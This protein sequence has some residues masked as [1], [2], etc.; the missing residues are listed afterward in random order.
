[1]PTYNR[2]DDIQIFLKNETPFLHKFDIDIC[3]F[4]SSE[5]EETREVCSQYQ[6][7]GC[8]IKYFR[9]DSKTS[10]NEKMFLIYQQMQK[11]YQF[12]WISH[13]HTLF[14]EEAFAYIWNCLNESTPFFFIRTQ[15][16][17]F[18][19]YVTED[20]CQFLHDSAWLLGRMGASIV[21]SDSFL[22]D[23]DW[24]KYTK[25]YLNNKC[26]NF[27]HIGFYF[28]RACEIDSFLPMTIEIPREYFYDTKRNNKLSWERESIRICT[29]C[30]GKVISSLPSQYINKRQ[31][32]QTIDPYFLTKYKL[33]EFKK[34]GI[35]SLSVFI[36]Y[37]Y[38][39]YL[40]FPKSFWDALLISIMPYKK[41]LEREMKILAKCIDMNV[42]EGFQICVYGA[43]KHAIECVSFLS[44]CGLHVN[45][46][47]VTN[48]NGNPDEINGIKVYDA[49]NYLAKHFSY[50]L[51]ALGG[52]GAD[53]VISF[54][55]QLVKEGYTVKY[56]KF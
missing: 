31:V 36:R 1:M 37:C 34:E 17:Q 26:H 51:V 38:W 46:I 30:W 25:K 21:N 3:I 11:E 35:Y 16:P 28:T 22:K 44:T 55:E 14:V 33:I 52:R 15:C 29:Q 41:S 39:I 7:D 32:L 20:K 19:S 42:K 47:L 12:I 56:Q 43:G 53:E 10:S 13:D 18:F 8:A 4:D 24:V 50:V 23:V 45:A 27:A 49:R 40:V 9:M 48:K 6:K 2:A 54:L 5:N